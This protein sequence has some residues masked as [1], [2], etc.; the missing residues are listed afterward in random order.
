[1]FNIIKTPRNYILHAKDA[2]Y[3]LHDNNVAKSLAAI[4]GGKL[5]G[6]VFCRPSTAP[7]VVSADSERACKVSKSVSQAST[8]MLR[9]L[10]TQ[11]RQVFCCCLV[12]RPGLE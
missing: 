12:W 11:N 3:V 2:N 7:V 8:T 4:L 6:E 10:L 5:F 9:G 1:M